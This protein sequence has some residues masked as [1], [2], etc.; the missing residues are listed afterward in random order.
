MTALMSRHRKHERRDD[1]QRAVLLE[2]GLERVEL[3][4]QL[5]RVGVRGDAVGQRQAG[6][7]ERDERDEDQDARVAS[8]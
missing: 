5:G 3:G 8:R 7:G 6:L 4:E 1:D 2:H